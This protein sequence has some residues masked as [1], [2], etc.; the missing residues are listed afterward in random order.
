MNK[1]FFT[2]IALPSG[3]K[4]DG[5][6]VI[7]SWKKSLRIFAIYSLASAFVFVLVTTSI[8]SYVNEESLI[9][10]IYIA[11]PIAFVINLLSGYFTLR[12]NKLELDSSGITVYL[13]KKTYFIDWQDVTGV[14]LSKTKRS[15]MTRA[16]DYYKITYEDKTGYPFNDIL[17]EKTEELE[18]DIQ[19]Y[20]KKRNEGF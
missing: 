19:R 16:G 20:F 5:T 14:E 17:A 2:F 12:K 15:G 3:V 10:F 11:M 8:M 6:C 1:H 7:N 4:D 13:E 18:W 9:K